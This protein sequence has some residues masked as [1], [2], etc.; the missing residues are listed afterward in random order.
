MIMPRVNTVRSETR[1][2]CAPPACERGI[3]L[4]AA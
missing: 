4:E 3:S 1:Q 2:E